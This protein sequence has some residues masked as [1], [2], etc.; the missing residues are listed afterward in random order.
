MPRSQ[1]DSADLQRWWA[2]QARACRRGETGC[3]WGLQVNRKGRKHNICSKAREENTQFNI[4]WIGNALGNARP[5]ALWQL[6][7]TT[8]PE[9]TSRTQTA[10]LTWQPLRLNTHTYACTHTYLSP[11][12]VELQSSDAKYPPVQ[13]RNLHPQVCSMQ[14]ECAYWFISPCF[15]H[16]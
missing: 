15:I 12:F 3:G 7:D 4:I 9:E 10:Q 2:R 16:L 1:R 5:R 11:A 13:C 6:S 14:S 8:C